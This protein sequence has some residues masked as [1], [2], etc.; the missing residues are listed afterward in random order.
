MRPRAIHY[1]AI[2]LLLIIIITAIMRINT[3]IKLSIS[4]KKPTRRQKERQIAEE[5]GKEKKL[6][7]EREKRL[8]AATF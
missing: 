5:A 4:H 6:S 2:L 1:T 8:T 7:G 3:K